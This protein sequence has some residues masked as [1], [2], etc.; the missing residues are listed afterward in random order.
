MILRGTHRE[1]APHKYAIFW[2]THRSFQPD[3]GGHFFIADY[4]IRIHGASNTLVVWQPKHWHGTTL[5]AK[6]P[7]STDLDFRQ[8][9]LSIVTPSRLP[10]IWR[11]YMANEMT[12]MEAEEELEQEDMEIEE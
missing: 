4:G 7:Q 1:S 2:T 9:G 12:A 8:S 10:N 11:K 6:D 5:S 3:D